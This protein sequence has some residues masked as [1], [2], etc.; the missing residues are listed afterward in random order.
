[1]QKLEVVESGY[2]QLTDI[3]HTLARA[4]IFAGSRQLTQSI[5]YLLHADR[6]IYQDEVTYVPATITFATELLCNS[7]DEAVRNRQRNDVHKITKIDVVVDLVH[8][9]L[10]VRDNGG[11]KVAIDAE[12]Q[13]PIPTMIFGH[14]RTGSNYTDDRGDVSGINGLGAKLVNIFSRGFHVF[15]SDGTNSFQQ[16]WHNNMTEVDN[17]FIKPCTDRFTEIIAEFDIRTDVTKLPEQA[18]DM[19]F[20]RCVEARCMEI[21]AM[22]A[23]WDEP[24]TVYYTC[25][26][27]SD[28]MAEVK[29]H[30]SFRFSRF[31]DYLKLW[32]N[33]ENFVIDKNFRF[34]VAVGLSNG[35]TESSA[36]VNALQCP[37]GNHVNAFLDACV[38][39]IRNHINNRFKIDIKPSKVK[40]YFKLVSTWQINAPTFSGQ[41]KE[42]LVTDVKDFGMAVIP[43]EQFIKKLLRSDIVT[44]IIEELHNRIAQQRK[45]ELAN[46]QKEIDRRTKRNIMPQKLTDA[47]NA[48]R[49][50]YSE[51][52]VVE[53]DSAKTG[54]VRFRNAETQGIFALFGKSCGNM[55]YADEFKV[56]A[57]KALS[58]LCQGLGFSF[59]GGQRLR[60]DRVIITTDAD[61]DGYCIRGL[62]LVFF[63]KFMPELI[64][65][66][67]LFSLA[68][69][70]MT[71]TNAKTGAFKHYYSVEEF[72]ADK[73]NVKGKDWSISY[74][75]GLASLSD[76][77]YDVIMNNPKL[78]QIVKDDLADD[79]ITSWFGNDSTKRKELMA[80]AECI[81]D[82]AIFDIINHNDR[83]EETDDKD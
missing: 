49:N 50:K 69:P 55:L 75:K 45:A 8:N 32:P 20:A 58:C 59:L 17:P 35:N 11:I 22:A 80:M 47:A 12:T 64:E 41:T 83:D 76:E 57:N 16:S 70:I 42:L 71:A 4:E 62:L 77:D 51:I 34:N 15:T 60:Y 43:S 61:V 10:T 74:K 81:V 53:G 78:V 46:Q 54:F 18:Y 44:T 9:S 29:W 67:R 6:K 2:K 13:L 63:N 72:E 7:F 24:L 65:Q 14:L 28:E 68:T 56:L 37:W 21:A 27:R 1:M 48:G 66:G 36:I 40:S 82:D 26:S 30:N 3:E 39:H 79:S 5:K 31:D 73:P 19:T 33:C 23:G 38:W 25:I 52:F